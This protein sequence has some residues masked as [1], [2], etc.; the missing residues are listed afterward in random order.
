MEAHIKGKGLWGYVK[1]TIFEP[2]PKITIIDKGKIKVLDGEEREK[3]FEEYNKRHEEWEMK[4]YKILSWFF[5]S[6]ETKIN[7]NILKFKKAFQVW[8][9]L[10]RMYTSRDLSHKYY[11][12]KKALTLQQGEMSVREYFAELSTIWDELALQEPKW[13]GEAIELRTKQLE[14]NHF[15]NFLNGLRPEFEQTRS[16]LLSSFSSPPLEDVLTKLSGEET[17]L[18]MNKTNQSVLAVP[19]KDEDEG[20]YAVSRPEE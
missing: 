18:G 4:N 3:A 7:A 15:F 17:R 10:E 1:G 14:E 9:Y 20:A 6:V 12:Q 8:E 13:S 19:S 11:L 5:S 16:S 2:E